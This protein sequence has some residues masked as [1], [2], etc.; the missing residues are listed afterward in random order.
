RSAVGSEESPSMRASPLLAGANAPAPAQLNDD[1]AS[2]KVGDMRGSVAAP[3]LAALRLG[4]K[5]ELDCSGRRR[6]T[7]DPQHSDEGENGGKDQKRNDERA[8][9]DSNHSHH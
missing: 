9:D 8:K 4:A 2:A 5:P 1:S 6:G 7:R 3:Q